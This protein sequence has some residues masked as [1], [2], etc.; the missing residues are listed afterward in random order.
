MVRLKTTVN[1]PEELKAALVQMSAETHKTQAELIRSG[2]QLV[3]AQH[4]SSPT[5][6]VFV[7][8]D[9][10]FAEHIDEHLVGFGE[11]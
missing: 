11:Q 2:I 6:P 1:L 8:A 7:S 3:L 10:I 5:I 9:P 4:Q